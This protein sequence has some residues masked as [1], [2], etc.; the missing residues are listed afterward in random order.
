ME[1]WRWGGGALGMCDSFLITV[2]S[3]GA[4]TL[5]GGGGDSRREEQVTCSSAASTFAAAA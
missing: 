4:D 2:Q 1:E 3:G 5:P